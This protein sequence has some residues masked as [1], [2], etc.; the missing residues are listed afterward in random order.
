MAFHQRTASLPSRLH[1]IESNVE[2]ELQSLRSCISAP[3]VT[4]GRMHNG[5]RRLG[6]LGAFMCLPSNQVGLSLPSNQNGHA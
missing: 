3:S 6:R 5:L 4:I 1:S 2:E